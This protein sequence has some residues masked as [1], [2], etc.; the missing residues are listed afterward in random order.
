MAEPTKKDEA[1]EQEKVQTAAQVEQTATLEDDADKQD[2]V[3]KAHNEGSAADEAVALAGGEDNVHFGID[4]ENPVSFWNPSPKALDQQARTA[5]RTDEK[6][7]RGD[8]STR[9]DA[10]DKPQTQP[11]KRGTPAAK[12]AAKTH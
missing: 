11:A 6:S 3:L 2:E 8:D 5:R 10:T 1:S 9:E 12:D 7:E 4:G